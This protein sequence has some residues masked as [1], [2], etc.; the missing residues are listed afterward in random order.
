MDCHDRTEVNLVT[1]LG[2]CNMFD[3]VESLLNLEHKHEMVTAI[4]M[5]KSKFRF[6][7]ASNTGHSCTR[8]KSDCTF[9]AI[10]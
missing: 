5:F 7:I 9:R 10:I 8:R 6:D 4:M 3:S 1:A 2:F